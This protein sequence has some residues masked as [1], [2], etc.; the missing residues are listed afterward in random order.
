MRYIEVKSGPSFSA[1][2]FR[3]WRAQ[4]NRGVLG[5]SQGPPVV[6]V[7]AYDNQYLRC[8]CGAS[9]AATTKTNVLTNDGL[10]FHSPKT[11]VHSSARSSFVSGD[12]CELLPELSLSTD[13][14]PHVVVAIS[15]RPETALETCRR[16][17][18][19]YYQGER[20]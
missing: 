19:G 17:K 15:A 9:G 1:Q 7:Q 12:A 10:D 2:K 18:L 13:H 16:P 5:H 14:C 4:S 20:G 6:K 3:R 8:L 11:P